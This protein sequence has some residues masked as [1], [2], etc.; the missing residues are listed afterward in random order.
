M[1][2]QDLYSELSFIYKKKKSLVKTERGGEGKKETGKPCKDLASCIPETDI[3][4]KNSN[5]WN[6]TNI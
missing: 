3:L 6:S 2:Y 5:A 1:N 4:Q